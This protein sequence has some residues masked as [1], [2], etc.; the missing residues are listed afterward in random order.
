MPQSL[1]NVVIHTVFSTK[2]REPFLTKTELRSDLHTYMGGIV[3]TLN[4]N[5]IDRR[6][7]RSCA[8]VDDVVP[9]AHDLRHGKR[10]E[11]RVD[12]LDQDERQF[13]V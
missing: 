1:A 11:A 4:C 9:H 3:K 10:S 12:K 13:V 7:I 6:R 2:N 5:P 8:H